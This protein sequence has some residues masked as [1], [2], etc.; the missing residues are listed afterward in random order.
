MQGA[1]GEIAENKLKVFISYSRRDLD[2]ADQLAAVLEWLRFRTIIDRKGIHGA[3]KWEERLGQLILE[4]DIVVFVL[5]P[6]SAASD[7][8][9][10]EVEEATRRGKRIIPVLCRPLEGQQ[11]HRRLRDLNY[12]HFYADKDVPGSGFGTGQVR[13]VEALS[14]DVAWLREHTRLEELAARWERDGRT[15]DL[16]VRGSELRACHV[17]RD[18]RP[19]NAPEL[20]AL[21]RT[22]LVASEDAEAARTS[23]E[24]KRLDDIAAAQADRQTALDEREAAVQREA[25]ERKERARTQRILAWGSAAVAFGVVL[26]ALGFA[27]VQYMNSA[28]QARLRSD[29]DEKAALAREQKQ[30]V[31]GLIDRIRI[32]RENA[33][34]IAAMKRICD[35]A[36]TVTSTLA[37]TASENDY[38]E[39]EQR[40]FELY[41]GP[42]NLIE[43]RQ[44]TDLYDGDSSKIV[45]SRIESAM[46]QFERGLKNQPSGAIVL[47]RSDLRS[48]SMG[49]KA[50]CDAYLP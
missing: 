22:F 16:L 27:A 24:R 20:T 4:S 28:E 43:I 29:A 13:L 7:V 50:E 9:A 33:P 46:V 1:S 2:F 26:S 31:D 3:E 38:R 8:C 37:S 11:P 42:M 14:V 44:R 39:H 6:A 23:A 15:S 10:W 48:L 19:T 41:F 12:I 40:F 5:S 17:W 49:I 34:G 18:R 35:E 36:V 45:S 32:G 21:Q 47:P 25:Q 30:V